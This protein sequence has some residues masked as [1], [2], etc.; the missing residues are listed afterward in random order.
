MTAPTQSRVGAYV[1]HSEFEK[2]H[3]APAG[4]TPQ[5]RMPGFLYGYQLC[6]A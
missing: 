4:I 1:F 2:E 6:T 3:P 5:S